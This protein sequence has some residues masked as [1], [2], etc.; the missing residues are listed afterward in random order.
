MPVE[1]PRTLVEYVLL[2]S[3]DDRRQLQDSPVLGD[4]WI[5]FAKSP[6]ESQDLLIT[7]WESEP[8]GRVAQSISRRL[9][10]IP[11]VRVEPTTPT[12]VAYLQGVAAARLHFR[13]LMRVVLPLTKWWHEKKHALR[14]E[15]ERKANKA[16]GSAGQPPAGN[17]AAGLQQKKNLTDAEFCNS[18]S[19]GGF[20][21]MIQRVLMP[22]SGPGRARTGGAR[23]DHEARQTWIDPMDRYISLTGLILWAADPTTLGGIADD[24]SQELDLVHLKTPE[25]M[26][27]KVD[28]PA[29]AERVYKLFKQIADDSEALLAR[30]GAE[31]AILVPDDP[32]VWQISLNRRAMPALEKS[33]LAVKADAA[34]SLFR[35]DCKDIAWAVLD[36]GI[37]CSHHAFNEE[38]AEER[39]SRIKDAFDFSKIRRIVSLDNDD[40]DIREENLKALCPD[41]QDGAERT[42]K[43]DALASLAADAAEHRPIYWDSVTEFV[44]I[45]PNSELSFR[46]SSGHG[47]HVA[48]IIGANGNKVNPNGMC[49]NIRLYDFRVLSKTVDDTEFAIIAAL[50]Y[51]RHLNGRS[52]FTKIHGVNLSLSIPHD[53]RNYACGRTPVCL[54]CERLVESGVVVVAAAGNHGWHSYE[55]K[56][57]LY[58][59]YS[60]FSITDP[61]NA[62]GVITVG[63]THRFW[64][65]TYGVSFFSSRGPTGDGRPKPDLVAP[66]ERIRSTLPN[67]SWGE[68]DGTSMAAP[69]VSAASAMLMARYPELI[70]Q[71]RRIKRILCDSATDLG[72]ERSFQG[73]GMLDVLRAFQS[74]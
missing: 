39:D 43:L 14:D 8:A 52:S 20:Q 21:E 35:V 73:R 54:E 51:I 28:R 15:Q 4:V 65:H 34:T 72:R 1:I 11:H 13:E 33:L 10:H 23:E 6:D 37:D 36:S 26:L 32:L 38:G 9:K 64:P 57:G 7:P 18:I 17:T 3:A 44:A 63:S 66:G 2:G 40:E 46:L 68:L 16:Q 71:P 12:K 50:Q 45:D 69:H 49:P 58:E 22:P 74:I 62:D 31:R 25:K 24:T 19:I 70:G 60:A 56:E 5:A 67:G 48:G 30:S 47:T 53:V 41:L 61:G 27:E 59:G 55:T 42:R 29:V